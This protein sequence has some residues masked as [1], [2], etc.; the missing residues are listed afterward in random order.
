MLPYPISEDELGYLAVHISISLES[1]YG[2]SHHRPIQ[3]LI[4]TDS[5]NSTVR[6]IE[7]KIMRE[8][9]QLKFSRALSLQEYEI[10]ENIDE[11]FI[12]TTIRLSEKNKPV[13][14]IAPFPTPY[15]LEQVWRLVMINQTKPYI[16]ER[17]FDE[18]Y[19]FV[20]NEKISQEAL[21][22]KICKKLQAD[23]YVTSDFY[24]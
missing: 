6:V 16:I 13:V 23:G 3:V 24:P 12:I 8:F 11:D 18:R 14:K 5:G 17:F 7:A 20:L 15:Q 19:F 21:F 10:L 22:K 2:T 1:N 9:P 4:I